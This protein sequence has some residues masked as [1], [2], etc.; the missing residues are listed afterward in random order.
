MFILSQLTGAFNSKYSTVHKKLL[1]RASKINIV[2]LL[3][4]ILYVW[5]HIVTLSTTFQAINIVF[6]PY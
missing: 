4:I 2:L 3:H 5:I 1:V 6:T